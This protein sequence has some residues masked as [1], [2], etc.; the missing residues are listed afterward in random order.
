MEAQTT[1]FPST[2][3]EGRFLMPGDRDSIVL[4]SILAGRRI[5][6]QLGQSLKDVY[7]GDKVLVT[8]ANDIRREYTIVGIVKSKLEMQDIQSYVTMNEVRDI[9]GVTDTRLTQIAIK[10]TD[11]MQSDAFKAHFVNEGFDK[12]NSI[13]TWA[14]VIGS[15]IND[16]NASFNLI[17][18]IIGSIGLM[19]G[20]ITI[21]ILIFIN[22][23]SKRRFIGVLKASGVTSGSIIISFVLQGI[24]YTLVAIGIGLIIL[25]GYMIPYVDRHPI[26][27]AFSDG[28]IWVTDSYVLIRIC[29]LLIVSIVSGLV[30]AY[31]IAKENTL[32]AI[33]GR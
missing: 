5:I 3:I 18:D 31:M 25:Y 29:V 8:Y 6:A 24:F 1:A 4:G 16:V 27:F 10:T 9:L 23:V 2:I 22:A 20:G 7:V 12:Q 32:N 11:P 17:A 26:N 21:F 28:I 19:V 15:F 30:P 13:Q 33:L 14:E